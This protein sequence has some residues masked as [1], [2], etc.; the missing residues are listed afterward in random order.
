MSPPGPRRRAPRRRT[1]VTA[2]APVFAALGDE[3]RLRLVAR[4]CAGGP[5]S[6]AQLTGG[7]GVTRQAVTSTCTC[8]AEAGLVRDSREGRERR[9]RARARA[10]RRGAPGPRRHLAAVGPRPRPPEGVARALK[11]A[12]RRRRRPILSADGAPPAAAVA[13]S[14]EARLRASPRA[15]RHAGA[16]ARR[17]G[18]RRRCSSSSRSTGRA[19]CTTTSGSSSTACC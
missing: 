15:G 13:L 9:W 10:A 19:G 11:N 1:A 3:T 16:G 8:S 7:T 5:L 4:L 12:G 6:I 18:A 14:P 2:A 17:A